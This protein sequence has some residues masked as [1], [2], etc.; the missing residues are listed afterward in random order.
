MVEDAATRGGRALSLGSALARRPTWT[1]KMV[2]RWI[3]VTA[4]TH[5][6]MYL[7]DLKKGFKSYMFTNYLIYV[8]IVFVTSIV[9]WDPP[10]SPSALANRMNMMV[11]MVM[12]PQFGKVTTVEGL[13]NM[14][15]MHR[16]SR[17]AG[18]EHGSHFAVAYALTQSFTP[19]VVL[20]AMIRIASATINIP[21]NVAPS[22]ILAAL[23]VDA[24][25]GSA[26]AAIVSGVPFELKVACTV[27]Y[28]GSGVAWSGVIYPYEDLPPIFQWLCWIF[29]FGPA[30]SLL[31][32]QFA[33]AYDNFECP[34]DPDGDRSG[35][36]DGYCS[37]ADGASIVSAVL[38]GRDQVM[39]VA[40]HQTETIA[41]LICQYLFWRIVF[42][43]VSMATSSKKSSIIQEPFDDAIIRLVENA[44]GMDA[45]IDEV[46]KAYDA[47]TTI[48][49]T[50]R[51]RDAIRK[52]RELNVH[53]SIMEQWERKRNLAIMMTALDQSSHAD[54]GLMNLPFAPMEVKCAIQHECFMG[55]V[56]HFHR[57]QD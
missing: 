6:R 40:E 55:A 1:F 29:P 26:F 47:A 11:L 13:G 45:Q 2:L 14:V 36:V 32:S 48:Q 17:L 27:V 52:A 22:F 50:T 15:V 23:T 7:S 31:T 28:A 38:S 30:I 16:K 51:H 24:I 49:E 8:C 44:R 10:V 9:Y 12:M 4:V 53:S 19:W 3:K 54:L 42:L 57:T 25:V 5:G 21:W 37:I 35:Y 18:N 41:I 33:L 20:G 56:K 46:A 39:W 34:E 43:A